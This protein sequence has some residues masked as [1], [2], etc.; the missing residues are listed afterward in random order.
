MRKDFQINNYLRHHKRKML[1]NKNRYFHLEE[2]LYLLLLDI[3]IVIFAHK[4][5]IMQQNNVTALPVAFPLTIVYLR[6]SAEITT[7]TKQII[8]E[9]IEIINDI[10]AFL[11][12]SFILIP[13]CK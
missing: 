2:F 8:T 4:I 1:T 7:A 5:V 12:L 10:L 3:N 6:F 9:N 13:P 11:A